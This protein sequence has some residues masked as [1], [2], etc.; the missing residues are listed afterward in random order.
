MARAA[1]TMWTRDSSREADGFPS[2]VSRALRSHNQALVKHCPP[3]SVYNTKN[4]AIKGDAA[5][6]SQVRRRVHLPGRISQVIALSTNL[7]KPPRA[8]AG[9]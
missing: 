7:D 8:P 3:L 9:A 5:A 1:S 4:G 6:I 2:A